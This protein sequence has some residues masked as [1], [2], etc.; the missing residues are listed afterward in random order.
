MSGQRV[1]ILGALSDIGVAIAR[2]YA[3]RGDGLIL[4]ARNGEM[5]EREAE[6]L[7]LRYQVAVEAHCFDVLYEQ[8]GVLDRLA[9]FP[10]VVISVVGLLGD[11]ARAAADP[12]LADLVF[13]SNFN[14]PALFLQNCAGRMGAGGTIIGISSVAGDRGRGSN[15][16]YGAAKAGFTAFLSGLRAAC[17][18]RGIR[19]ITV[20][21]AVAAALS[22]AR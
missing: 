20:K 18:P 2:A 13:R 19:V 6:H 17:L 16:I 9:P 15:Y 11:Q 12:V 5:L 21:P 14:A 22:G 4:L 1:M 8:D 7:R 3:A 10:D